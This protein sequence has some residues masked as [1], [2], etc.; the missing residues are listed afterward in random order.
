M[1][2]SEYSARGDGV[3]GELLSGVDV[4]AYEHIRLRR[5]IG[6]GV[7]LGGAVG[8][9]LYLRTGEQLLP[10][11]LLADA[12]QH[13]VAGSHLQHRLVVGRG[14]AALLVLDPQALLERDGHGPAVL[15]G[16]LHRAEAGVNGDLL[17]LALG[18]VLLAHGHLVIALQTVQADAV[19]AAAG[20]QGAVSLHRFVQGAALTIGRDR[21]Q[22]IELDKKN[23]LIAVDSY[24]NTP[25]QRV[26]YNEALRRTFRD[27]RIAFTEEQVKAETARCLGCGA[28]VVDPNKC[29]G[30]GV[31]TTKCEFG[32]IKLHRERPECSNMIPSEKKLPY[33]LG[34]GAKQALKIKFSKKKEQ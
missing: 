1:A 11:H 21:R 23:A 25:R 3:D 7:G 12:E 20:K 32:A 31:C 19:R 8:V 22:F 33:V 26:G 4:A 28:S 29:I 14:K 6:D 30:C 16:H 27:E 9:E 17:P 10:R 24:D 5:L 13:R 2:D 34:N 18:A 15:G